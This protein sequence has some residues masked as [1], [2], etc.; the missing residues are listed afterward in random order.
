[1]TLLE[2]SCKKALPQRCGFKYI[3]L[4]FDGCY[5]Y[6]TCPYSYEITK[7][8]KSFCEIECLET[9]KPYNCIC[10][11]PKENCFW[12][13]VN[14]CYNKLY[15][16]NSC[17]QE[18]D[19]VT[20][21]PIDNC[22]SVIMGI[23]YDCF[24]NCLVVAFTD[25]IVRF[26]PEFPEKFDVLETSCDSWTTGV[27]SV[28]P[29]LIITT[30]HNGKQY[31]EIYDCINNLERKIE[32]PNCCV[33]ESIVFNPCEHH[34]NSNFYF[35]ILATKNNCYSYI[36]ECC[37]DFCDLKIYKCNCRICCKD[38]C[39]PCIEHPNSCSDIIESIAL[40][41]ASLSHI[42]NAEGEKLQK[43]IAS[44]DNINTILC[45]NKAVNETI[46][47][48]THLEIILHDKLAE[49]KDCCCQP[50]HNKPKCGK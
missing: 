25:G 9:L 46:V 26:S 1:M 4:A 31:L 48:V 39:E 12:A 33:I 21:D 18:I 28:A 19:A 34:H 6:L 44:T 40:I 30:L 50:C 17:F 38:C 15:K 35:T 13:A 20:V 29:T 42:L 45:A 27:L 7:F 11:D 3:G 22:G 24:A 5:F 36:L 43:I 14:A 23:S 49:L 2:T 16:L 47:N 37:F 32:V 41:E 8:D 10:Y